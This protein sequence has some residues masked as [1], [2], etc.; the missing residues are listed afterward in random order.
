MGESE[1]DTEGDFVKGLA[2]EEVLAVIKGDNEIEVVA[3]ADEEAEA[4]GVARLD[5]LGDLDME[6][7]LLSVEETVKVLTRV[8]EAKLLPDTE[9]H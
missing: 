5:P 1:S 8:A 7:E 9:E 2:E 6:R 3:N 4:L